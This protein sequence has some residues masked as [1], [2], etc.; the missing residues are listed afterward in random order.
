MTKIDALVD[1]VVAALAVGDTESGRTLR[2]QQ[3]EELMKYDS[4]AQNSELLDLK[5]SL[6]EPLK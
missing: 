1:K 3:L 2:L 5:K 6:A 4:L